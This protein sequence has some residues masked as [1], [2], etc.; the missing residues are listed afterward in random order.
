[1]TSHPGAVLSGPRVLRG[2]QRPRTR[3]RLRQLIIGASMAVIVGLSYFPLAVIVSNSLKSSQALANSGPFSLFTSFAFRNYV[4]AGEGVES[5]LINTILVALGAVVIGVPSAALAAYGFSQSRFR[6]REVLFYFY[7]GLLMIPWTLTMIPLFLEMTRLGMFNTW[8]ALIFPYAAGAQPLLLFI[9]RSFFESIPKELFQSA[10]VDGASE[11]QILRKIVTPLARP[12]LLT[13]VVLMVVAVWGD[14]LWPTVV[15][16][17]TNKWTV[18]AGLQSFISSFGYSGQ[19]G[20]AVF[21]AYV[22]VTLP[23]FALVAVTMKYFLSGV[24]A[25]AGKL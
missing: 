2:Q 23:L 13:G 8:W 21:A 12:V 20:G 24:T 15:L 16:T 22:I 10:R 14:Y 3:R 25:G 4:T 5:Y 19:G 1:M 6:G 18:S 7:L 11:L 9:N 17:S